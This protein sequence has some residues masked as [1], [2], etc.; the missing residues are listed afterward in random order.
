MPSTLPTRRLAYLVVGTRATDSHGRLA[1]RA[2]AGLLAVCLCLSPL[3]RAAD[4]ERLD[5]ILDYLPGGVHAG[6]FAAEAEGYFESAG[7]DVEIQSPT[8]TAD[9]LRLVLGDAATIGIAPLPDVAALRASGEPVRAFQALVQVPLATLITTRALGID[10]LADLE[11]RTVGVTGVPSDEAL[12]RAMLR[13]AGVD[14]DQVDLVTIGFDSARN[15]VAGSVAAALGFWTAEAVALR[16]QG[17]EPVIF[18]PEAHGAPRYPELVLFAT[19]ATLDR[20]GDAIAAFAGALAEG[21]DFA[22][23]KPARALEHLVG[24]ADG[25]DAEFAGAELAEVLPRQFDA[26]GRFGTLT[27]RGIADYLD[28]AV[29]NGIVPGRPDDLVHAPGATTFDDR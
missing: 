25:L 11:G 28:W 10:S 22:K 14:L 18:R 15:L 26:S 19:E 27:E 4:S 16:L 20:R 17:E 29:A 6:L 3:A 13:D 9:T 12:T 5:L 1:R 24:G 21:Y 23:A 7:L 8:S 2:A